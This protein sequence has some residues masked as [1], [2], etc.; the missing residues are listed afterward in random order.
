MAGY[1]FKLLISYIYIYIYTYIH[2]YVYMH[3]HIYIY[4]YTHAYTHIYAYTHTDVYIC[5][6]TVDGQLV[7]IP[8]PWVAG[9][10][11]SPHI[12]ALFLLPGFD[13]FRPFEGAN[14]PKKKKSLG[15]QWLLDYKGLNLSNLSI[16]GMYTYICI[17]TYTYIYTYIH[18][19][20]DT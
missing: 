7:K 15:V 13:L 2:T 19:F 3:I 18:L 1:L 20:V 10:S 14:Q 16:Y 12:S 5:I 17:H 6:H 8:Y 11:L 4:I 9:S